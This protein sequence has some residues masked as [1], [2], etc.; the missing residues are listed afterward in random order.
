[1]LFWRRSPPGRTGPWTACTPSSTWTPSRSRS[2]ENGHITN[3]A[4]YI[5]IGVNLEGHKEVLGL[6]IAKREGAKFWLQSLP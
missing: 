2:T 6:W 3:K 1:M 4:L 5:A